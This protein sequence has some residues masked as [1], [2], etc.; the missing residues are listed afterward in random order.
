MPNETTMFEAFAPFYEIMIDWETRLARES[1]MFQRIFQS[2][3]AKRVLDAACGPGRHAALFAR[4]GL[5]VS[6]SDISAAMVDRAAATA[7]A[8]GATVDLCQASFADVSQAFPVPFDA[9]I[10]TG[11]S[12]SAAGK[13]ATVAA[14]IAEFYKATRP[15]GTV[16]LQVLNYELFSP[17]ESVYAE[18][19]ARTAL[20]QNYI[21]LKV[22]RRAGTSCDLDIVVL[23]QGA[24]ELWTRTVFKEKL[25]VLDEAALVEMTEKA[26]YVRIM[27]Y[28]GPDMAPFDRKKSEH[29]IVV[30]RKE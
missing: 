6:A 29:L 17:G 13:R 20:G 10:C 30:A 15:G 28:G 23:Q 3:H 7:K 14:G 22:F 21:F 4:W 12:L 27:L 19:L 9:V 18:P 11:N 25:L 1:P 8:Q 26:G 2:V 24:N 5:E 16:V